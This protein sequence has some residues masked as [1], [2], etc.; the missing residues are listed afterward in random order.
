MPVQCNTVL[1]PVKDV[2]KAKA[3]FTALFGD[4][5][6]DAPFY[7]GFSV[8]GAEIGLVPG[9]HDQGMTGP[10]PFF[11]VDDISAT[12]G[13]LQAAGAQLVQE[14]TDVGAGL[15]VAKVSDADGNDIGL[16]QPPASA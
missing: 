14:P 16:R 8:S 7:V 6:V 2:D 9:G 5:H 13:A 3:V 4:P 15:L 10:V 1:Y 11:D 12:L